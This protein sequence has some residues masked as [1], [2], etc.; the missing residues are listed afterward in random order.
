MP[1][2]QVNASGNPKQEPSLAVNLLDAN[3][4]IAT[5]TDFTLG[6]PL[7]GVYRSQDAG[8]NW[9]NSF[10]PLPPGFTGAEAAFAAYGFPNLFLIVAHVF[11]GNSSGTIA[12]YRST[13]NGLSFSAPIIVN[14]GYGT[15]INNDW[16]KVF[17]DNSQ[18]SPFLGNAYVTYNRQY[19]VDSGGFS[20][21]AFQ[22]SLDG[23][24]TWEAPLVLSDVRRDTERADIGIDLQGGLHFGW[25]DTS[26]AQP[27]FFVR[28]SLDGGATFGSP[29]PVS[30]VT[31]VPDVL[32]VPGYA[33]RV[34]NFSNV[35]ADTALVSPGRG[36]IYAVW[37]DNRQGYADVYLSRSVDRGLT[38]NTP[39]PITDS[40]AGA[41]NFFP[42]ITVSPKTGTITVIYYTNR[43]NGFDLDVYAAQ[44]RDGG[45]TFTNIRVTTTS[46]NPN[47]DSPVP[48]PLIGDYIDVDTVPPE[49]F[50]AV[51]T[52]TRTGSQVTWGGF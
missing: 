1:N 19:N 28:R 14:P 13:D 22:R 7:T 41:Q 49:N 26:S 23:G 21:A 25:I 16:T 10:L 32:P 31:L 6:P 18:S 40:P 4:M 43:L 48:T 51:W 45:S 27:A 12:A 24:V 11:P 52:D 17:F 8:V 37:Q 15:F 33:F 47:G 20:V 44:S 35:M 2:F 29:I 50:Y 34:L 36:N 30:D 5:A 39:I 46:F 3:I 38:W 9:T 42:A